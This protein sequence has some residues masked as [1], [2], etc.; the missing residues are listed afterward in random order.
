ML[1]DT[2]N[3][4]LSGDDIREADGSEQSESDNE[5]DQVQVE[6]MPVIPKDGRQNPKEESDGTFEVR[7][8]PQ[9]QLRKPA[10]FRTNCV[11]V[12]IERVA[13]GRSK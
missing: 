7:R 3:C 8:S 12:Q 4:W 10:R 1:R 5:G 13:S 11:K 6:S 2:P 9:R